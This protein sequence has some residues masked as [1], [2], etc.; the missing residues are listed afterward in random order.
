[1]NSV[2]VYD[3][4]LFHAYFHYFFVCN[5]LFSCYQCRLVEVKHEL[6]E[7]E[8][9]ILTCK[10]SCLKEENKL[11]EVKSIYNEQLRLM[12]MELSKFETDVKAKKD[13]VEALNTQHRH[14]IDEIEIKK[15][16]SKLEL[17]IAE[18]AH[19]DTVRKFNQARL[20]VSTQRL[21]IE[22]LTAKRRKLESEVQL[23]EEKFA[24]EVAQ[25]NNEEQEMK[26]RLSQ[27][28]KAIQTTDKKLRDAKGQLSEHKSEE[29]R[30]PCLHYFCFPYFIFLLSFA[31]FF[32]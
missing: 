16:D 7:T 27:L 12:Q 29:V 30:P 18:K 22:Q 13:M 2:I 5:L 3:L 1:M 25:V 21:E 14:L 8:N 6:A 9:R 28:E 26:R 11:R 20:E 19:E 32:N 17:S 31:H 15:R 4:L 23:L 24:S 10:E